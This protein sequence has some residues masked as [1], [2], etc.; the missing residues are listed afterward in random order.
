MTALGS[1]II[2]CTAL[3]KTLGVRPPDTLITE[4]ASVV[5]PGASLGKL[6]L[7][8]RIGGKLKKASVCERL[9]YC[10]PSQRTVTFFFYHLYCQTIYV[11]S[12]DKL[13]C[14]VGPS[15]SFFITSIVK[16]FM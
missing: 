10:E 13:A 14:V 8:V 4:S 2:S 3:D 1:G 12:H 11:M 15:H 9:A 7:V 6:F 16:P 5:A